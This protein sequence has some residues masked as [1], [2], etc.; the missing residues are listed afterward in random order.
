[1]EVNRFQVSQSRALRHIPVSYSTR[2][3]ANGCLV[4]LILI[5][6]FLPSL[7]VDQRDEKVY[8]QGGAMDRMR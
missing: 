2:G 1:M 6:P 7:E 4:K 8:I 3:L 5:G